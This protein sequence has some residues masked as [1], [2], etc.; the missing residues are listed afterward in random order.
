[1]RSDENNRWSYRS[2]ARRGYT[3]V[4]LIVT[5]AACLFA[6]AAA[7]GLFAKAARPTQISRAA[8]ART[9]YLLGDGDLDFEPGESPNVG[10][11]DPEGRRLAGSAK[12]QPLTPARKAASG[13][14][15]C[16]D[17]DQTW[18]QL[19]TAGAQSGGFEPRQMMPLT[20]GTVMVQEAGTGNWFDLKPDSK[21]CYGDGTWTKLAS[22]PNEYAPEYDGSAVLKSGQ[23][24]LLGGEYN[25]T[26]KAKEEIAEKKRPP[27]STEVQ[28]YEPI[29]NE[30][31]RVT[32]PE[33]WGGGDA[34]TTVMPS[35][36]LLVSN[37]FPGDMFLFNENTDSWTGIASS[38]EGDMSE[39]GWS[40]LPNG[41]VLEVDVG[42][43]PGGKGLNSDNDPMAELYEPSSGSWH[44]DGYLPVIMSSACERPPEYSGTGVG[45]LN[46]LSFS[47][48]GQQQ[49]LTNGYSKEGA[50]VR[51]LYFV[52]NYASEKITDISVTSNISTVKKCPSKTLAP[53]ESMTCEGEYTTTTSDLKNE[54]CGSKTSCI[55]DKSSA[56]GKLGKSTLK[57]LEGKV[58]VPAGSD[59]N[60]FPENAY[61]ISDIGPQVLRPN[62][63]V[64]AEG[65]SGF[66]A[67]Y[68]VESNTWATSPAM[69][70][71]EIDASIPANCG[72]TGEYT[73]QVARTLDNTSAVLPDGNVLTPAGAGN[74]CP[75]AY[76]EFNGSSVVE[77]PASGQPP[78][79]ASETN[80]AKAPF[81]LVLP[82]GQILSD[83]GEHRNE[84]EIYTDTNPPESSWRPKVTTVA[85]TLE[86][87]KTYSVN[88]KQLDGLTEG[89]GY[90]DDMQDSTDF[91]LV[92]IENTAS[93]KITY[94]RTYDWAPI[95]VKPNAASTARFI[96]PSSIEEG[97]SRLRV[98]ANGIASEP[99]SVTVK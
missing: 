20:N 19:E 93:E 2:L 74:H 99:V 50:K 7:A 76:F 28:I 36:Q 89:T 10:V 11:K 13:S 29:A 47:E 12:Y 39:Q 68:N 41:K 52:T 54:A 78:G 44:E 58:T 80:D 61:A 73:R 86:P 26:K 95:S 88:G 72:E 92:Q 6:A 23:V 51:F 27:E 42:L 63:T 18:Q 77:L 9:P 17:A 21:G 15:I 5:A 79:S 45:T 40:L 81:F 34:S 65:A 71:P 82:T 33:K 3:A 46:P 55:V 16:G 35:G 53:G 37:A 56:Q 4:A 8:S 84:M 59:E 1:M 38:D 57:S 14:V 70:F 87:S 25:N 90:G 32:P 43:A 66:N 69:D 91:P 98:I 31:R 83:H 64:F 60:A 97:A 48:C 62:G 30:W 75:L 49:W 24:I 94:A 85:T 67:L 22:M 96:M